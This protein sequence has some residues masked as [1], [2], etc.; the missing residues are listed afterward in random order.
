VS[1]PI[2]PSDAGRWDGA[3]TPLPCALEMMKP[4]T[5]RGKRHG[6]KPLVRQSKKSNPLTPRRQLIKGRERSDLD[7]E[8]AWMDW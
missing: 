7:D 6:K 3:G 4:K 2:A 8:R 5:V 1:V